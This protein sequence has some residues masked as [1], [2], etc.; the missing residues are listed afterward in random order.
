MTH[1]TQKST[2][3]VMCVSLTYAAEELELHHSDVY[4]LALFDSDQPNAVDL[5]GKWTYNPIESLSLT[6]E[7]IEWQT[8]II[9]RDENTAGSGLIATTTNYVL[10]IRLGWTDQAFDQT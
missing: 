3:S 8:W 1:M 4:V 7:S 10:G 9:W 2:T 6:S 5:A